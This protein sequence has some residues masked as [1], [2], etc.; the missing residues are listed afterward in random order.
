MNTN[1]DHYWNWKRGSRLDHPTQPDGTSTLLPAPPTLLLKF[2]PNSALERR[3]RGDVRH[4]LRDL[5]PHEQHGLAAGLPLAL[6]HRLPHHRLLV[7]HHCMVVSEIVRP[8]HAF[9]IPLPVRTHTP[10]NYEESKKAAAPY[11][12]GEVIKTRS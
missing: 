2:T 8:S 3:V 11:T 7:L 1:T 4:P 6:V 5:P 10:N 9:P 12:G